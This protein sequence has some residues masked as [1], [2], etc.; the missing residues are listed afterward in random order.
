MKLTHVP[1]RNIANYTP[2][3]LA[4][5]V[6]LGFQFL[7]NISGMLKSGSARALA[8]TSPKRMTAL[9]DVPTAEEAGVKALG[10]KYVTIPMHGLHAP[11]KADIA[12]ALALL[13]DKEAGPVFV[14]CLRGADRTGTVIACY[15]VSHDQWESRKALQ[16]ARANGMSWIERAMQSFILGYQPAVQPEVVAAQ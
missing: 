12:K 13:E 14:H 6:P 11:A 3:F 7:P 10:M 8:V 15:R 16:E 1:Y 2:D 4:G 9:P 5:Q